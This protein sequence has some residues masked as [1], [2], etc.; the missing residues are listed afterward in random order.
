MQ[1]M[2]KAAAQGGAPPKKIIN[3]VQGLYSIGKDEGVHVLFKGLGP[4]CLEKA[5]R[6][7][8]RPP[9]APPS[10]SPCPP[11]RPHRLEQAPST[12]I[13]YIIYEAMKA[14]LKVASV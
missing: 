11:T 3:M 14:A 1:G 4:A 8:L 12:A 9:P 10:T 5:R 13:G 7:A 2:G 6:P